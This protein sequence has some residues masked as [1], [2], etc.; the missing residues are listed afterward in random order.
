VR[1]ANHP[2]WG[3][4]SGEIWT[5]TFGNRELISFQYANE[6]GLLAE[7][8][9]L[10]ELW[11][12]LD[13]VEHSLVFVTTGGALVAGPIRIR[14]PLRWCPDVRA[15]V[16]GSFEKRERFEV[17]VSLSVPLFGRVLAYEGYIDS[18][19]ANS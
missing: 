9:W 2:A 8:F 13:A 19:M 6:Q 12:R 10:S 17:S 5:R 16:S 4:K 3:G 18:E 7:R 15:R 14:F 1:D 11:F